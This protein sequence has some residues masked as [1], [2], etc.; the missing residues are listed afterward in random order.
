MSKKPRS[1]SELAKLRPKKKTYSCSLI[2]HNMEILIEQATANDIPY[3][4]LLDE[5]LIAYIIDTI[6]GAKPIQNK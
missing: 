1:P 2:Q 5:A 4:E 6:P 3:S